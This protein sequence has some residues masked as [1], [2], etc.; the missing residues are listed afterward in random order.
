MPLITKLTAGKVAKFLQGII[1]G[2]W[3]YICWTILFYPAINEYPESNKIESKE[4][5]KNVPTEI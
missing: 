4:A 3:L 5:D 2:K 1:F